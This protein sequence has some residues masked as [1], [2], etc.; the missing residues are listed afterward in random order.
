MSEWRLMPLSE[1]AQIRVSNVDKKSR[2][3]EQPVKLCNYMDVYSN[4]YITKDI[5]FMESTA[6]SVE[7]EKF[8]VSRG[9]VI[10]TKDSETPYDIGIPAVVID[11]IPELVCGYHLALIKPNP[12]QINSVYLAK[13]LAS[14]S[15]VAYFSRMAAG[16]T[17][18]GLSNGAIS[19]TSIPIAP[20]KQQQKIANILSKIDQ[21]IEKT[22]ALI[23]KYQQIKGGLMHDLFTRGVT[24]DGK[25]RP[26]REQA[27]ELYKETPV[28]WIPQEWNFEPIDSLMES[29][30]DGP[31]GS[32][33]KTVHYVG[34]PGVPV[35]RLQNIQATTYNDVDKAY[36]SERHANS[37]SRNKVVSGDILIAGLGEDRY[38]VGRACQ[39]PVGLPPAINKADC[40]RLKCSATEADNSYVMYYLNTPS[41]RFQIRHYEQG[42]TRPRINLGNMKKIV[43]PKPLLR[44]QKDITQRLQ[45][46]DLQ[47]DLQ[48][49][50]M[51]KLKKQ[52]SGL[53][54]DLLTGKVPVKVD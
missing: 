24:A 47:I 14:T 6:S 9:D 39:Y 12:E 19:A 38:P 2:A 8:K 11:D 4:D 43:I 33:L 50:G 32:N 31:F 18:Y 49:Q 1:I 26:P 42:V 22:K 48:I 16:S 30:V 28:G 51:M 17:R 36:I 41:A 53:M 10:I 29:L 23:H 52:K 35:V 15:A 37:L 7:K 20:K 46:I 34:D 13:Q 45:S 27:P 21:A 44:E 54:H 40:F 25:L 3:F 5:E